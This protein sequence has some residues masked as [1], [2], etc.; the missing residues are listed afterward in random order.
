MFAQNTDSAR[1]T[2]L[3]EL[4]RKL[5]DPLQHST[6]SLTAFVGGGIFR[7]ERKFGTEILPA[8]R[9][10]DNEHCDK[11]PVFTDDHH[12]LKKRIRLNGEL[13]IHGRNLFT[14]GSHDDF[15]DAAL[16]ADTAAVREIRLVTGLQETILREGFLRGVRTV[17]VALHHLRSAHEELII[18]AELHLNA[19]E[20]LADCGRVIADRFRH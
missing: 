16:D 6:L 10:N 7:V 19:G 1:H 20:R 9:V 4:T 15:L 3:W 13:E 11:R 17:P 2:V 18:R 5:P 8:R 12:L 14:G